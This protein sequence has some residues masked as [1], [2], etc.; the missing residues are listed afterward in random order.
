MGVARAIGLV[1]GFGL[2]RLLG[3]PRRWHPV[4]GFGTVAGWLE[5]VTY[6]DRRA[7]G[8][9]HEAVL[10]GGVVVAAVGVER[11]T[12]TRSRVVVTALAT[13]V[14]LGGT[15][16]ARTGREMAGYLEV[17]EV[18]EARRLLPSLCGRDPEMLD[19]DGLARATVESLAENTSDA[20][21][22]PL[23]WGA[24]AGVPGLLGYRA[25][26]TLDAMVG[27]RNDRY[28]RF[29]WAAARVDDLANLIPAR[30]TGALTVLLAPLAGGRPADAL[31][32]WR[33]DAAA[34]PSPNAGVAE[35]AMAGALGIRLGGPTAYPHGTE[36]RPTLGDGPAPRVSDLRRTVRMSELVQL[37][38]ALTTAA[39]ALSRDR[40]PSRLR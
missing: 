8:V 6:R 17:G 40:R 36:L 39:L 30:L 26:N 38:A 7:A 34:H 1:A 14:A 9:L 24:V 15:T 22:A 18:G 33:R 29:G 27:Y 12:K 16:L 11:A 5:S 4:A 2:D 35:A 23:F 21:V 25:V 19:A 28:R 3:D 32:A 13:W 20:A 31:R 37:T 10:V